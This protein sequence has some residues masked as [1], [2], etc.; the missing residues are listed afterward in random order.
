MTLLDRILF[1]RKLSRFLRKDLPAMMTGQVRL[2][3]KP[4]TLPVRPVGQCVNC[5]QEITRTGP[6]YAW[7]HASNGK[8][9]CDGVSIHKADVPFWRTPRSEIALPIPRAGA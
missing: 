8:E 9:R 2:T 5:N 4:I 7:Y 6:D 3:A 1:G